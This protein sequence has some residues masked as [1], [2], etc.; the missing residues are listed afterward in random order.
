MD[1]SADE[2]DTAPVP[3]HKPV[4][5]TAPSAPVVQAANTVPSNNVPSTSGAQVSYFLSKKASLNPLKKSHWTPLFDALKKHPTH[6]LT[7]AGIVKEVPYPPSQMR[8][9]GTFPM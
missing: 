5:H 2:E 9:G 1:E 3:N 6:N 8:G 4:H 7:I